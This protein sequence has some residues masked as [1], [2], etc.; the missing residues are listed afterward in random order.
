MRRDQIN[1]R[2]PH[3]LKKILIDKENM[4]EFVIEA[5]EDKLRAERNPDFVEIRIQ[6]LKKEIKELQGAR[7]VDPD[8][9]IEGFYYAYQERILARATPSMFR[10][11]I[12]DKVKP[13]LT[14]IGYHGSTEDILNLFKDY[15]S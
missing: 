15:K 4:S 8:N 11:W 5:I 6:E 10:N 9:I 14:K 1:I 3:I 2:V 12:K 13:S 7:D